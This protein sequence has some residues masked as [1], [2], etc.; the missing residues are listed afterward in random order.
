MAEND[1]TSHL[2]RVTRGDGSASS[3]GFSQQRGRLE[4]LAFLRF[5]MLNCRECK[6]PK[7]GALFVIAEANLSNCYAASRFSFPWELSSFASI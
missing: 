1:A 7:S 2:P 6:D 4:R 5:A 3:N